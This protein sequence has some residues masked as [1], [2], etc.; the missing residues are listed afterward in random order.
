[1]TLD[2]PSD[3]F[4]VILEAAKLGMRRAWRAGIPATHM[5][6]IASGLKRQEAWQTSLFE[7]DNPKWDAVA[8]VKREINERFGRFKLRSGAT[9]FANDFYR[10]PANMHDV[11]DIRGKFCF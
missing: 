8:K 7:P 1:M 5:H 6:L 4:N 3:R 9:L 10:D 11:C 2:V